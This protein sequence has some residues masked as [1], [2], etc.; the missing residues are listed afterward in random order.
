[1]RRA[2]SRAYSRSVALAVGT[3]MMLISGVIYAWSIYS[4]PFS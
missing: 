2:K 1:M 4:V 3:L